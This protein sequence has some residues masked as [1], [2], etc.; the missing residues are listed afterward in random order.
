MKRLDLNK[1]VYDEKAILSAIDAF[2]GICSVSYSEG[3]DHW[4]CLFT[5]CV[6]EE[7]LT[8]REFENYLIDLVNSQNDFH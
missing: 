5:D 8:V 7:S 4:I 2:S 6:A 3:G 1:R